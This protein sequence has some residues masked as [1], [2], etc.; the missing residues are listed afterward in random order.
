[1]SLQTIKSA[2]GKDYVLVPADVYR[3]LKHQIEDKIA[4]S[5]ADDDY[6]PFI[7]EDYVSNPVSLARIHAGVTQKELARRLG[8]TQAYISKIES[9]AKVTGKL[10]ERVNQAMKVESGN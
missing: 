10:L 2:D 6:V 8:V 4:E 9:Q 5:T 1:M 3:A 7:I